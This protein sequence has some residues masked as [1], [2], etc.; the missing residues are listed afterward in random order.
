VAKFEELNP[1]ESK[2]ADAAFTAQP[3]SSVVR[4]QIQPRGPLGQ[5]PQGNILQRGYQAIGNA[6]ASVFG[7]IYDVGT[8]VRN[9]VVGLNQ[10][11]PEWIRDKEVGTASR[12]EV[13]DAGRT[14]F[15]EGATTAAGMGLTGGLGLLGRAAGAAVKAGPLARTALTQGGQFL[16]N[17]LG[18][19]GQASASGGDPTTGAVIGGGLHIGAGLLAGGAALVGKLAAGRQALKSYAEKK[20]FDK[21][22]HSALDELE[23][24]GHAKEVAKLRGEYTE[25]VRQVR[26]A[27]QAAS[28][29]HTNTVQDIRNADAARIRQEKAN[30]RTANKAAEAQHATETAA[31][32]ERAAASLADEF[33]KANP[34]LK[35]FPS[36]QKGLTDMVVGRGQQVVSE[37]FDKSLKD[38]ATKGAGKMIQ[39]TAEDAKAL[40]VKNMRTPK[41][42]APSGRGYEPPTLVDVDAG[43]VAQRMTGFWKKDPKVYR[44]AAESLDAANIGDPAARKAYSQF[45]GLVQYIDKNKGL[46]DGVLQ[47]DK[48]VGGLYDVGKVNILRKRGLGNVFEGPMQAARGGPLAPPEPGPFVAGPRTPLPRKPSPLEMP[49]KPAMPPAPNR[50]PPPAPEKNFSQ[51]QLTGP[52]VGAT[53]GGIGGYLTGGALGHPYIGG[54]IGAGI[55]AGIGKSA[56]PEGIAMG[57][58]S[59]E[60]ARLLM[61]YPGLLSVLARQPMMPQGGQ[62]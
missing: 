11:L 60:L 22:F 56:F 17:I 16:G 49:S 20:A 37:A 32:S 53:L 12:N 31:H 7:S 48:L 14:I 13:A 59:P 5:A 24:Q 1:E 6:G 39:M 50:I 62:Q 26:A 8:P 43:E 46:K 28:V 9:A 52:G 38:V 36:D 58:L 47:A 33:K 4:E 19:A 25:Q 54:H 40:G 21:E 29:E 3:D 2:R 45:Q 30:Y 23:K 15:Q 55:G 34:A 18:G 42:V 61:Q 27:N 51:S 41:P 57:Q 44:R 10:K 35:D